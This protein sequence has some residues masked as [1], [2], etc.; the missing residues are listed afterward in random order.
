MKS[1]VKDYCI[2]TCCPWPRYF[3]TYGGLCSHSWLLEGVKG[4]FG[5]SVEQIEAMAAQSAE[6]RKKYMA[7]FYQKQR[8]TDLEPVQT[9]VRESAA[10]YRQ[11]SAD[12]KAVNEQ[13]FRE[14]AKDEHRLFCETCGVA[15][16]GQ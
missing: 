3:I 11:N 2:A 4:N 6:R 16:T 13:R 5:F 15:C 7:D 12:K 8:E 10:T 14:K 9:R 1:K